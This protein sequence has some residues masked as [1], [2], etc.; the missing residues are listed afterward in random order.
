MGKVSWGVLEACEGWGE[1]GK[2]GRRQGGRL[3]GEGIVRR[4]GIPHV[5]M[6][7]S[8][9]NGNRVNKY[10]GSSR[11]AGTYV[12]AVIKAADHLVLLKPDSP[13][14]HA[15]L[16]PGCPTKSITDLGLGMRKSRASLSE[17]PS[18]LTSRSREAPDR[19]APR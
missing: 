6:L 2:G 9:G 7:K 18:R 5:A 3:C 19:D 10:I 8:L 12:E 17:R 16:A 1:G 15:A 14:L 11:F 13:C 4:G